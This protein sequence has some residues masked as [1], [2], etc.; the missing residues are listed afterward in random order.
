MIPDYLCNVP[1]KDVI[2]YC[3]HRPSKIILSE[4]YIQVHKF[5]Q[6]SIFIIH[7]KNSIYYKEHI[8]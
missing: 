8:G 4:F 1:W 2:F 5:L 3:R 7:P 6:A